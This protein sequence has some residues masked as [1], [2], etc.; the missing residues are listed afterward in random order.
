MVLSVDVPSSQIGKHGGRT[1]KK[2]KSD[3]WLKPGGGCIVIVE[4]VDWWGVRIVRQVP[5]GK[6][7]EAI[8]A[9]LHIAFTY[10]G[11]MTIVVG[12]LA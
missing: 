12:L 4:I 8:T 3:R 2:I 5:V 10:A 7:L 11:S 9:M 6:A 1:P